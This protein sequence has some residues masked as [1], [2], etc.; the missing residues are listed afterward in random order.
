M[1]EQQDVEVNKTPK[2]G[3]IQRI[4]LDLA[5]QLDQ[6]IPTLEASGFKASTP[7]VFILE[8]FVYYIPRD[9]VA[10]ILKTLAG[11]GRKMICTH[12]DECVRYLRGMEDA[13][14]AAVLD[15][16]RS[17]WKTDVDEFKVDVESTGWKIV[18]EMIAAN[19][20]EAA[21][22]NLGVTIQPSPFPG[23]EYIIEL[24]A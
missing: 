8:G 14:P 9:G 17:L 5:T 1:R 6:L 19:D 4:P 12:I 2:G 11:P 23:S 13:V 20:S 22:S 3:S 21:K 24:E 16:L 15:N 7:T 18:N 10:N